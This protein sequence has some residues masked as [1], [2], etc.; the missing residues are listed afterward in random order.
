[1]GPACSSIVHSSEGKG[2]QLYHSTV[3]AAQPCESQKTTKGSV[4]QQLAPHLPI[5]SALDRASRF[6]MVVLADLPMN[7]CVGGQNCTLV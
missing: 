4:L 7:V 6:V 5:A 2:Q 1:M 3:I